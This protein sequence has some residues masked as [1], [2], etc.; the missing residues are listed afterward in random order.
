MTHHFGVLFLTFALILKALY[1]CLVHAPWVCPWPCSVSVSLS[2]KWEWKWPFKVAWG[3]IPSNRYLLSTYYMP[4]TSREDP[5]PYRA[6]VLWTEWKVLS[7]RAQYGAQ[8]KVDA[9]EML[10]ILVIVIISSVLRSVD[11]KSF[12]NEEG[13]LSIRHNLQNI[14]VTFKCSAKCKLTSCW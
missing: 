14:E 2:T 1:L 6:Y 11:N 9:Q 3:F 5:F 12:S 8:C 13:F 10:P 7:A 4:A